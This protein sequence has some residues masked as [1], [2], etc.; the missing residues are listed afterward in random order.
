M[1]AHIIPRAFARDIRDDGP[2]MQLRPDRVGQAK[3]QLGE[4][5]P[6]ILCASC[7]GR[8]GLLDDYAIEVC[9]DFK[10]RH[11]RHDDDFEVPD[12]DCDKLE[13]LCS[14]SFGERR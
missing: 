14:P 13:N 1:E 7:D 2:N 3:P 5:D 6:N 12:I 4:Y 9:R 10:K 8:L 11:T